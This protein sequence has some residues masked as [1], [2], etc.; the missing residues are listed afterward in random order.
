MSKP[1]RGRLVLSGLLVACVSAGIASYRLLAPAAAQTPQV[2][3]DVAEIGRRVERTYRDAKFIHIEGTSTRDGQTL[4]YQYDSTDDSL[5]TICFEGDEI[6]GAFTL[7]KGRV[8]EFVPTHPKRLVLCYDSDAE[9]EIPNLV[10]ERPLSCVYGAQF[11]IWIG[12]KS[13]F[14]E[15]FGERIRGGRLSGREVINDRPCHVIE[16]VNDFEDAETGKK[17]R[18]AHI[19]YVDVDKFVLRRWDTFQDEIHQQRIY[20]RM[21]VTTADP[22]E[23]DWDVWHIVEPHL[24]ALPIPDSRKP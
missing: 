18:F 2:S 21:D 4:R 3:I 10:Y 13:R 15:S 5:R 23:I 22:P 16:H 1:H 20:S 14:A 9:N 7:N 6:Y 12:P 11:G 8:Q 24:G 17:R 19:Y